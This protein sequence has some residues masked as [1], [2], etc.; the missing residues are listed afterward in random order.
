[1]S[2]LEDLNKD[3][4]ELDIYIEVASLSVKA[5]DSY[6]ILT[7]IYD[8]YEIFADNLPLRSIESVRISL[9]SKGNYLALKKR[10]ESL[11]LKKDYTVSSRK[12]INFE[13]DTKYY[14]YAIDVEKDYEVEE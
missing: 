13:P 11:L 8:D 14:H 2:I 12:Y 5:P 6:I 10:L 1:M 9:F 4:K 3:L 7:P